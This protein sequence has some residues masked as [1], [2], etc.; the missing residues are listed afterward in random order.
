MAYTPDQL[1]K[2]FKDVYDIH[3]Q[4]QLEAT[5]TNADFVH[6]P[7]NETQAKA[8]IELYIKKDAWASLDIKRVLPQE[9]V[10][11]VGLQANSFLTF[12]RDKL[13]PGQKQS[14][15]HVVKPHDTP[16]LSR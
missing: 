8:E 9:N 14:S 12:G 4:R 7:E 10:S 3:R 5:Q 15:E 13:Q 2:Q 1:S 6:I 11:T 16:K